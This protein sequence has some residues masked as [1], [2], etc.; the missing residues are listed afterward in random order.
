MPLYEECVFKIPRSLYAPSVN[1]D[2]RR[3]PPLAVGAAD[4]TTVVVARPKNEG[5]SSLFSPKHHQHVMK[6]VVVIGLDGRAIYATPRPED[7]TI[8]HLLVW[9]DHN[10]YEEFDLESEG[11]GCSSIRA[12]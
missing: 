5:R 3:F 7:G 9:R 1:D 10:V 4:A 2:W 8:H 6:F 12:S 11:L